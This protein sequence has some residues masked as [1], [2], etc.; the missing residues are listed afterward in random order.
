MDAKFEALG[1]AF[2]VAILTID[3]CPG[4]LPIHCAAHLAQPWVLVL[5]PWPHLRHART[6]CQ[7]V[8]MFPTGFRHFVYLVY[9][10][11]NSLDQLCIPRTLYPGIQ[12]LLGSVLT[13]CAPL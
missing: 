10:D 4:R 13:S 2:C 3:A 8:E 7:W 11:L 12:L 1:T 9:I 6:S 5:T